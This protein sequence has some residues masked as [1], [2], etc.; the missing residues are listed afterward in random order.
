MTKRKKQAEDEIVELQK[1]Y[2]QCFNTSS[3]KAVMEDLESR[4]WMRTTTFSTSSLMLAFHEGQR[5]VML[6]VRTMLELTPDRIR[7][8]KEQMEELQDTE[9]VL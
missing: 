5:S 4:N 9:P 2:M 6:Y 3:G 1:A 8:L 7:E